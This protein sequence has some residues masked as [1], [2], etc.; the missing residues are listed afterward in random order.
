MKNFRNNLIRRNYNLFLSL[1]KERLSIFIKK[2]DSIHGNHF[3][4]YSIRIL[5]I[6]KFNNLQK[7]IPTNSK[8]ISCN[9]YTKILIKIRKFYSISKHKPTN[10]KKKKQFQYRN[11][12]F[13]RN[14]YENQKLIITQFIT[15]IIFSYH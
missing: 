12:F 15:I 7:K 6:L 3:Y 5:V 4:E 13:Q 10:P 8:I 11:H 1:T 9:L 14:S 2:N